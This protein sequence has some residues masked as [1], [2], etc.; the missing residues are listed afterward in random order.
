[1]KLIKRNSEVDLPIT[2]N[3]IYRKELMKEH[4]VRLVFDWD[5][6]NLLEVGDYIIWEGVK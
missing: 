5:S 4:F 2:A 6:D 3:S 1:M